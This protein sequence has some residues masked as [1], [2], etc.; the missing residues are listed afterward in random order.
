MTAK[1]DEF[2]AFIVDQLDDLDGISCR[3]MF[4]G[5]GVYCGDVFFGILATG[6][7]YLKT[8]ESTRVA[9]EELGMGPFRFKEEQVSKNYFEVPVD[10]IENRRRLVEWAETSIEVARRGK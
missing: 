9:Y 10:V 8:D 1:R 5:H 6:R 2:A 3:A 4:G 7:L